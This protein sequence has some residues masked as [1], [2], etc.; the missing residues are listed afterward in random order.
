MSRNRHTQDPE[1]PGGDGD[2]RGFL[3]ALLGTGVAGLTA[4][5]LYPVWRFIFPPGYVRVAEAAVTAG[6]VDEFQPDSGRLF[7]LD[8]EPAIVIRTPEGE[9]RAFLATC[10]HLSCTVEYRS[11]L[12]QIYCACHDGRFDLNGRNI[13]GPPPR[14]LSALEVQVRDG[15]VLVSRRS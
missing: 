1:K 9:F 13:A 12:T 10:T 7:L 14:P 8:G 15:D 2:R 4:S 11:D 5:I 6:S 3:G